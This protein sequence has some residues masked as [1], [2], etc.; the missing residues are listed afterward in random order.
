MRAQRD[1][2]LSSFRC[3]G[4]KVAR[5]QK[6]API[7]EFQPSRDLQVLHP[8]MGVSSADRTRPTETRSSDLCDHCSRQSSSLALRPVPRMGTR[9]GPRVQRPVTAATTCTCGRSQLDAVDGQRGSSGSQGRGGKL[10]LGVT[11]LSDSEKSS[12]TM[13]EAQFRRAWSSDGDTVTAAAVDSSSSSEGNHSASELSPVSSGQPRT[14]PAGPAAQTAGVAPGPG[15][16]VAARRL[17]YE[18]FAEVMYT[19]RANLQHT[20]AVQQRLFQQQLAHP[21][22]HGRYVNTTLGPPPLPPRPCRGKVDQDSCWSTSAD[23]SAVSGQ[24]EWVVR[25]RADGTRYITRR[26]AASRHHSRRTRDHAV[27]SARDRQ[28]TSSSAVTIA[29][30]QKT[31]AGR[32]KEVKETGAV[33]AAGASAERTRESQ[34]LNCKSAT[35]AF[36]NAPLISLSQPHHQHPIL[37]VITI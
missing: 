10:C 22:F 27:T 8:V 18:Q 13:T 14:C 15:S 34:P 25:R 12:V 36:V 1:T 20:I 7:I 19:N 5:Q 2:E 6:L 4:G 9:L 37:A 28:P 33:T 23:K 32:R 24:L 11:S 29:K 3:A 31:D 17:A 35:A 26:P 21:A 16:S 30:P